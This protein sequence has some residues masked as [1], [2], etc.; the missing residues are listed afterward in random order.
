VQPVRPGNIHSKRSV[1]PTA[2]A[3]LIGIIEIV[4]AGEYGQARADGSSP[5]QNQV[6]QGAA[7]V[8]GNDQVGR[9]KCDFFEWR[10]DKLDAIR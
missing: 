3:V 1:Q 10:L 8:K 2:Q 9:L 4:A 7:G 6:G 5:L